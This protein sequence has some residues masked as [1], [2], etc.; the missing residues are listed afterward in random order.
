MTEQAQVDRTEINPLPGVRLKNARESKG[1]ELIDVARE[2]KLDKSLID[3]LEQGDVEKLPQPV[4]TAGYIRSYA[5]L[6]GLPA[7]NMV[8]DYVTNETKDIPNLPTKKVNSLPERYRRVAEALPRSFS[9]AAANHRNN[10]TVHYAAIG[11]G[12]FLVVLVAWQSSQMFSSDS[13]K[14]MDSTKAEMIASKSPDELA[15]T[16]EQS[17]QP[18]VAVQNAGM[19]SPIESSNTTQTFDNKEKTVLSKESLQSG[20]VNPQ[21]Q[22]AADAEKHQTPP[23]TAGQTTDTAENDMTEKKSG[24]EA[25]ALLEKQNA[26]DLLLKFN[27]NSWVD[28]RDSTGK[29]LIR[30]L[31]IAGNAQTVT[32]KAPFQVLLG[33][34]H[35]VTI[36]YNGT[37]VDFSA[38]QGDNVAR[39]TL[40]VPKT[41]EQN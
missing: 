21:Q 11:I 30:K 12:V 10:P 18:E 36:E 6:M 9:I 32:G 26:T 28:I 35:G 37:E 17:Q 27:K 23:T 22:T 13:D 33:Y 40:E 8:A 4:Y 20:S 15:S 34:G 2:L 14:E 39:F 16:L 24:G 25:L 19:E 7:D 3:A 31:G 5:R 29:R 1:L 38:F 41:I